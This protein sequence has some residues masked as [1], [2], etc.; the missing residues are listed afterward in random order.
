VGPRGPARGA[1]SRRGA[2]A[3]GPLSRSAVRTGRPVDGRVPTRYTRWW[4]RRRVPPVRER[5]E[6]RCAS[7]AYVPRGPAFARP[8]CPQFWHVEK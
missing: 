2:G 7:S 3:A 6:P 1:L 4:R 8:A 5:P